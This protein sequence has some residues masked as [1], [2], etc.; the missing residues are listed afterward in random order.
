M[1]KLTVY[2]MKGA[3]IGDFDFSDELIVLDRGAQAVQD[4]VVA[5]MANK[6]AGTASTL[7][8]GEVHGSGKK[9]WRQKGT[10]RARAGYRQ[11]PVWRGGAVV[12]GPRPRDYGKKINRKVARLALQRA[13]S[14]KVDS[15]SIKILD[16]LEM[17]EPKT[18]H[19]VELLKSLEITGPALFVVDTLDANVAL[20]ARNV[21]R[22]ELVR[23][24][25]VNVYQLLRYPTVVIS[26]AAMAGIQKRL[27]AQTE[28]EA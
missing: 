4:M 8:K 23:A 7:T 11:S 6:R 22:I 27:G 12:F 13:F 18:R 17:A 1:S 24:S 16:A 19:F 5:H 2:D 26:R 14:E 9:P 15:G 3:S 28:G 21:P 25:D 20:A 10:G